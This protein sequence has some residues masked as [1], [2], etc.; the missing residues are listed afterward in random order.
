MFTKN[1]ETFWRT[2][3]VENLTFECYNTTA[4]QHIH[5]KTPNHTLFCLLY[6]KCCS[7]FVNRQVWWSMARVMGRWW[8]V[9]LLHVSNSDYNT[10]CIALPV[11][12]HVQTVWL[13]Q[14]RLSIWN[15]CWLSATI[16]VMSGASTGQSEAVF[17]NTVYSL[18]WVGLATNLRHTAR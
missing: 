1:P 5:Q 15:D 8:I 2:F 4:T 14:W 18:H 9:F 3:L 16:S 17:P 11:S 12:R 10:L 6:L 13:E 7:K